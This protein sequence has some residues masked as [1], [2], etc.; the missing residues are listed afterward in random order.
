MS[1]TLTGSQVEGRVIEPEV[2]IDHRIVGTLD[3]STI[4]AEIEVDGDLPD[5]PKIKAELTGEDEMAGTISVMGFSIDFV[6]SRT[7]KEAVEFKV[8]RRRRKSKD[9]KPSPPAVDPALEPIRML[10]E[11]KIPAVVRVSGTPQIERVIEFFREK[12]K[13]SLVLIEGDGSRLIPEKMVE[14]EVGL[15]LPVKITE[16]V[17]G[18]EY[19]ASDHLSRA[20]V[21][22]A[23]QSNAG[24]GARNLPMNAREAVERGLA[25]DAALEALTRSA[26]RL[27]QI[28][29]RVGAIEVGRDA[30][31]LIFD[32]H[33]F[34]SGSRLERVLVNGEEVQR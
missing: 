5:V 13:L 32:G 11:G 6:A 12:E 24:D 7:S 9:G 31:L 17:R 15:V 10:L 30:D 25:P 2:P 1:L 27:M 21:S 16:Q 33:P 8:E 3:G 14:K 20:G 28:D 23:F 18:R 29:D 34:E 22:V 4:E 26:A 19:N